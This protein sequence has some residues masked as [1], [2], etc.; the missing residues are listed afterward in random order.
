MRQAAAV[1]DDQDMDVISLDILQRADE[2]PAVAI[3]AP[4]P[5]ERSRNPEHDVVLGDAE[6]APLVEPEAL[7]R[8]IGP[9]RRGHAT[10]RAF[11]SPA[12]M[13]GSYAGRLGIRMSCRSRLWHCIA[14]PTGCTNAA[15]AG[16]HAWCRVSSTS[17]SPR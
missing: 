6:R 7:R 16:P 14:S 10:R 2:L 3:T 9:E 12:C 5:H 8:R 4:I 13:G 15:C 1:A 17:C 11:R